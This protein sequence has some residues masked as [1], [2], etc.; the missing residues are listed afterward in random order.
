MDYLEGIRKDFH[1]AAKVLKFN[2]EEYKHSDSCY[3]LGSYYVTG[4]GKEGPGF[5]LFCLFFN[6]FCR[7]GLSSHPGF[8]LSPHRL[9]RKCISGGLEDEGESSRKGTGFSVQ[10]ISGILCADSGTLS[11]GF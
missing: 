10:Q 1:E 6:G 2:C 4:K 11:Q 9:L 5:V 8:L 3:K 7:S